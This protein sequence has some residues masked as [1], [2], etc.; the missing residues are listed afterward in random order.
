MILEAR[1]ILDTDKIERLK[2][3]VRY[4]L[5]DNENEKDIRLKLIMCGASLAHHGL[6]DSVKDLRLYNINLSSVP[7]QH[8]TSL[9]SCVTSKL[10]IMNV[11]GCDMVTLLTCLKCRM[12]HICRQ[13][14]GREDTRALVQAMH[15]VLFLVLDYEVT[16]DI[17]ALT[18]YNGQ[19][20]CW[21]VELYGDTGSLYRKKL[22][23]WARSRKWRFY[24]S[25]QSFVL[26]AVH[27]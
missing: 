11:S 14:L 10:F 4:A 5:E 21:R 7:A 23:T 3:R 13:S 8:L 9:A 18:K 20:V 24:F 1:G 15:L 12:L 17:D 26:K 25:A 27:S 22:K 16:L 2:N 19:G 6:L